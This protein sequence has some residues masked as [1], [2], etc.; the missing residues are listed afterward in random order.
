M[1]L[2]RITLAVVAVWLIPV[3]FGAAVALSIK[4]CSVTLENLNGTPI[5]KIK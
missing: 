4:S 3:A 2:A 5:R 1:K